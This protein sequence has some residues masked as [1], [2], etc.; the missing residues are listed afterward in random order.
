MLERMIGCFIIRARSGSG[1]GFRLGLGL[2][3]HCS[4]VIVRV[5]VTVTVTV[6]VQVGVRASLV[7][8]PGG[9]VRVWPLFCVSHPCG[10]V[11]GPRRAS[12]PRVEIRFRVGSIAQLGFGFSNCDVVEHEAM[13][14]LS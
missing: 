14:A 8:G 1:S 5:S 7:F 12:Q 9:K 11:C 2:D 4:I 13:W 3:L 6:T 10:Q